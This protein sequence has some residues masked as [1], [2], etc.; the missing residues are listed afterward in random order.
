MT[1]KEALKKSGYVPK[2]GRPIVDN[3]PL[4]IRCDLYITKSM[5]DVIPFGRKRPDWIR[6]AIKMRIE[7]GK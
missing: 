4:N 1:K 5:S 2:I 6:G 3:E 7:S